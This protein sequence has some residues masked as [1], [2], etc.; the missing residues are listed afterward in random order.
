MATNY[1]VT[2]TVDVSS[3]TAPGRVNL[4]N[5]AG[6]FSNQ[7]QAPATVTSYDI[8]LPP[9]TG[10]TN[11]WLQLTSTNGLGWVPSPTSLRTIPISS[12]TYFGTATAVNTTLNTNQ[13]VDYIYWG[14]TSI[15]FNSPSEVLVIMSTNVAGTTAFVV[16]IN[17]ITNSTNIIT[18]SQPG[19]TNAQLTRR[20]LG[21]PSNLS[22]GPAVWEVLLRRNA[23][24][25][26]IRMH[27]IMLVSDYALFT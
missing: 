11:D 1:T 23:A 8:S 20:S 9:T 4:F 26:T 5:T 15:A 12:R 7:L 6:T 17:D 18:S 16:T 10:N 27:Q 2:S 14:G 21:A 19:L 13:V 22:S 24:S 25:G 3:T